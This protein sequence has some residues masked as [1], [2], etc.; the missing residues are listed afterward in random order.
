[1]CVSLFMLNVV[2]K[3]ATMTIDDDRSPIHCFNKQ[4]YHAY[5]DHGVEPFEDV[6]LMTRSGFGYAVL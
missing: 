2:Q 5:T 6:C 4:R 3:R 1:M